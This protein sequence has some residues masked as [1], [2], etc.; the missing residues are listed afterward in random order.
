MARKN[1]NRH[2]GGKNKNQQHEQI[3]KS[4][5]QKV[6]SAELNSAKPAPNK[7]PSNFISKAN[8]GERAR[9]GNHTEEKLPSRNS[10]AQRDDQRQQKQYNQQGQQ[11]QQIDRGPRPNRQE[12]QKRSAQQRAAQASRPVL[13]AE[14]NPIAAFDKNLPRTIK[15]LFFKNLQEA[16]QNLAQLVQE[17]SSCEQLNIVIK[18]EGPINDEELSRLG[19]VYAGEA[20]TLIHQRRMEEGWYANTANPSVS[21]PQ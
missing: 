21:L 7:Q 11:S 19:T 10:S 6:Q 2:R 16:R 20:W 4:G 1:R 18:D 13:I 17:K 5:E 3:Q 8:Q 15:V 12:N 9:S 14:K